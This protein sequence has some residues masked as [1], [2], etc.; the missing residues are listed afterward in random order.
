MRMTEEEITKQDLNEMKV[1]I[2]NE[3]RRTSKIYTDRYLSK[4]DT[5]KYLRIS[6]NTLDKWIS[7]GFPLLRV[8]GVLRFDR[9]AIDKWLA[10]RV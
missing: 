5:C 7:L 1:D 9:I 10:E 6:N 4:K 3:I 8:N 2:V